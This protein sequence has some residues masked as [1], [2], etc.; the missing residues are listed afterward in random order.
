[1]T[2]PVNRELVLELRHTGERLVL[3]RTRDSRG[4]EELHLA[5]SLPPHGEG[6]PLHIH[7]FEDEHGEVVSGTL[8]ATLDGKTISIAAGG[9]ARFPKGSAHRWWN[10][11]DDELV[12]RGVATPAVDLDRFLH[13]LF[14][15]L[16]S[17][18]AGR[19][20]LF[21]LAHVLHRHRK[22]QTTLIMP[23]VLQSVSLPILVLIGT[24]LGRYRGSA[25]PGCPTRCTGVPSGPNP[26][27]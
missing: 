8:S 25:W 15:V 20:P 21:Y 26:S 16:N 14:E 27:A 2:E 17:G 19:P 10:A 11:G 7:T 13:A 22:T 3:H 24:V 4:I 12:F 1:M 5:G 18:E 9:S 6:P 23:P